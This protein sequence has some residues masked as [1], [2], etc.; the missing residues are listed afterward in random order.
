ME[1]IMPA[2][3]IIINIVGSF[4]LLAAGV[5]CAQSYP[6]KPVRIVVGTS[7]GNAD[8]NGRIVAQGIAG[9]LGQPVVVDNRPNGII[10]FEMVY[11][12]P[13]DG[14]TVLVYNNTVWLAPLMHDAPYD[15]VRDF[16]PVTIISTSPSILAVHP[17]LP[18]KTVKELIALA[19]SRP[20]D[21]NYATTGSGSGAHLAGELFKAMAGVNIVGIPYKGTGP[22]YA[23]LIAGRVHL[24]VPP[25]GSIMP[26]V[27]SGRLRALAITSAQSSAMFPDLPTVSASGLPGYETVS[28]TGIFAPAK[29]P[30]AIIDRLQQ[31]VAKFV[32]TPAAKE[33]LQALGLEA[34]GSTPQ[35][36]ATLISQ[37]IA[38]MGKVIKNAGI[39][40]SE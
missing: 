37:E 8:A 5:T 32:R 7:G 36:F 39:R 4:I 19:K 1:I 3:A 20:G 25:A 23:D 15:P 35:E 17:S 6:S 11:K 2:R 28:R 9:A 27:K 30:G 21:L 13:P 34:V 29:T 14:Y 24:M 10:P 16:A 40:A 18:A 38:S 26:H 33:K 31:E 12:A 22:A